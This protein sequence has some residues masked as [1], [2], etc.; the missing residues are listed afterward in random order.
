MNAI[1]RL[2]ILMMISIP[3]MA[4]D[5]NDGPAEEFGEKVDNAAESTKD[6]VK[7]AADKVGDG[8]E[9]ACEKV[10]GKNC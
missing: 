6:T 5:T 2:L 10:S 4:C 1:K 7:D 8:V 9:D 3:L